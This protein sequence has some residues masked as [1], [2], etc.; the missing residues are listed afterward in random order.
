MSII[1]EFALEY[2]SGIV[3]SARQCDVDHAGLRRQPAT[4]CEGSGSGV[5]RTDDVPIVVH[6]RD[7]S[8]D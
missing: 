5:V 3:A 2:R 7:S 6:G 8:N 1:T 4:R